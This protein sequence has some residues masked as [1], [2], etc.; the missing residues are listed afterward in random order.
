[1]IDANY[2]Q[3]RLESFGIP[4]TVLEKYSES[5]RHYHTLEH[6]IELLKITKNS[7]RLSSDILFLTAV[8]HDIIYDPRRQDNEEQ[9][10]AFFRSVWK[11]DEATG[12]AV[13]GI[14]LE[15]KT[16]KGSTEESAF[17]QAA[18]LYIFDR[19]LEE[20]ITHER[21][22][23]REYAFVDWKD[24]REGRLK[25]LKTFNQNG[26]TEGLMAYVRSFTPN[27][28]VYAGSFNPFHKGHYNILLKAEAIFDK[29]IIAYGKNPEKHNQLWPRPKT[30]EYRQVVEYGGLITDFV[31]SLGYEVT[32]VRGLRNTDD[33][34]NE[35]KQYRYM[36]DLKPGIKSVSIYCDPEFEH[37]SSTSIRVLE[38]YGR[39]HSYLV[40]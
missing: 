30:I 25:L 2:I 40:D 16:H 1:M 8:F 32:L 12:K 27:I 24:Y 33:F 11:G 14:I 39:H 6:I 18:D 3:A 35:L 36:K 17:F 29:V 38:K 31:S 37:I 19:P 5:H 26:K 10:A 7:G 20:Q 22:V 21:Q 28:G 4:A 9:S 13:E 34:A 15:T 23:F